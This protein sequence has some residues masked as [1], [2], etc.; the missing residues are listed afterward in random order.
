MDTNGIELLEGSVNVTIHKNPF[1]DDDSTYAKVKRNKA[2]MNNVIATILKSSKLLDKATLV[3][4]EMLFKDAILELLHNGISVSIFELWTLSLS[5]QGNIDSAN[6]SVEE[7]PSLTLGF[8]PSDAAIEAISATGVST[9]QL[10]E[11]QPVINLLEDLS[12]HKTD[13]TITSGMPIRIKGRRLK[14]A[15]ED[16]Q[17]GLF[18]APQQPDGTIKKDESDW[19]RIEDDKFFKNTSS[20]L[21]LILPTNL[22][23]GSKYTLIV[24]TASS[25]GKR[26]NKTLRK[27][28][29]ER[30]LTVA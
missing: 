22:V 11:S 17:V 26:I 20:Y 9:A 18:F 2:G 7:I 4:A 5:A 16:E 14:I 13:Y 30:T 21:E 24:R 27:L 29:F 6:P 28:V 25:R 1:K 12:T 15:G 19:I 23:S 3:A 8:T 10:E